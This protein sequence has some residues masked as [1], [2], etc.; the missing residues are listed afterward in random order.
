MGAKLAMITL[1][2]CITDYLDASEKSIHKY[3]KIFNLAFRGMDTLGVDFFYQIRSMKLPVSATKTVLLP[4]DCINYTKVGVF[5][6]IGEVIPL[7]FNQK[8][9]YYA[10]QAPNRLQV[11][12]DNTLDF[13]NL[14]Y[15][16]SPFFYNYWADGAYTNLY[17]VPSGAPFVGTFNVDVANGLILLGENFFYD[18]ICL[19]YIASPIEGQEYYIPM[20]FREALI[21]WLGWQDNLYTP[22]KSHM[23]NAGSA[24]RERNFWNQR[25]L[26]IARYK[27]IRLEQEYELQLQMQ[28]L[29]VKA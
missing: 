1:D 26:A 14:Y 12:Q 20:Q 11:T 29:T 5:N 25:R 24:M 16:G 18:Y 7:V 22:V 23:D 17:G 9:T 2:S 13:Q 27:P 8:L 3:K 4:P 28:R 19:E 10:D 6:S 15:Q 21:A